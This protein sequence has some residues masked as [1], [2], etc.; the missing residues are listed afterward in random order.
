MTA[1]E[2]VKLPQHRRSKLEP[3]WDSDP[4]RHLSATL[5]KLRRRIDSR[6]KFPLVLVGC[7][8]VA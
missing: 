4:P 2:S 8:Q 5:Q 3:R 7:W 6:S 1:I